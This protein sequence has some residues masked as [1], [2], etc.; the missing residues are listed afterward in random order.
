MT[1]L[2][3]NQPNWRPLT[4]LF[5]DLWNSPAATQAWNPPYEV[6]EAEGHYLVSMETPGVPREGLHIEFIEG[7]LVVSGERRTGKFQ[8]SFALP[9]GINADK[10]EAQYLDGVLKIYIPKADSAKPRQIKIADTETKSGFFAKL[11]G[12]PSTEEKSA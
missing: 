10:V 4:D 2:T 11:L 9:T 8:R 6:E 3:F 7:R 5:D 1:Y 12:T